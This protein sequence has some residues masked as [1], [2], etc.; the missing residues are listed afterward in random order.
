[1]KQVWF[2]TGSSRGLGRVLAESVL[3]N[4][5]FL[6]ATARDVEQLTPLKERF[7]ERVKTFSL[8][9][10]DEGAARE[11]IAFALRAFGHLDVLVNNAGFGRLA[12]FEQTSSED[13]R[14]QVETNLY[15]VVNLVRAALPAMRR[16][17]SGYIINVSSVGGRLGSPGLSA[18]Q[19][20]K[21]A[22]GGF[23][24]VLAK[25]T[26][27]FGVKVISVEP[28]GMRTDWAL[29]ATDTTSSLPPEYEST[30]G[31]MLQGL[32]GYAGREV[33]D[34]RKIARV[35]LNLTTQPALPAHLVLGSDALLVLG[36]A[37]AERE[38][39]AREWK[40]VSAST[41]FDGTDRANLEK[42]LF[43]G[44]ESSLPG[45]AAG[46]SSI[47]PVPVQSGKDNPCRFS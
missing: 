37:Q 13:F 45:D 46:Y 28:G 10:T 9:V 31:A 1:M 41:D 12:P 3:E 26:A 14:A 42:L 30:V 38:A 2:I 25:E 39:A 5:H 18:Y 35:I 33:G 4:G 22:V 40:E 36:K 43:R 17:R 32:K 6:V 8:D 29:T 16:Q 15:G 7:G 21:W 20:A 23:T 27:P 44:T 11:A 34:P 24:E 19:A 47:S